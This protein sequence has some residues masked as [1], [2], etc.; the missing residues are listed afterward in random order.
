[1]RTLII[2]YIS[3]VTNCYSQNLKDIYSTYE[4]KSIMVQYYQGQSNDELIK[5]KQKNIH[6]VSFNFFFNDTI[7]VYLNGKLISTDY[8]ISQR[9]LG[10]TL[11]YLTIDTKKVKGDALITIVMHNKKTFTE[12]IYDR[13]YKDLKLYYVEDI[14]K[15]IYTNYSSKSM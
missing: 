10:T 11:K 13:R 2:L 15:V 7:S 12:I 9:T 5:S 14:F 4:C 3:L 1:M 6:F 8:Y